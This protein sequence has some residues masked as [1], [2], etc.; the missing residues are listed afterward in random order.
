MLGGRKGTSQRGHDPTPQVE[1]PWS[2][3]NQRNQR[4]RSRG[5]GPGEG[6]KGREE[7]KLLQST[8]YRPLRLP[9]FSLQKI[10]NSRKAVARFPSPSPVSLV[11]ISRG[12]LDQKVLGERNTAFIPSAPHSQTSVK[13]GAAAPLRL[14]E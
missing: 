8:G 1:N 12:I 2:R 9:C 7:D 13:C 11:I 3:V 4:S 6:A 10:R 5:D 14:V